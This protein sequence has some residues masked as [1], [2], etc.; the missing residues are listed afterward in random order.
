MAWQRNYVTL[1]SGNRVRYAL[2]QRDGSD[3]YFVRFKNAAG[4]RLER[5]TGESKK[6]R[7]ADEAHRFIREE[8]ESPAPTSE[9]VSW[10]SAKEQLAQAL[11]HGAFRLIEFPFHLVPVRSTHDR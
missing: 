3:V 10:E 1:S 8:Y 6:P 11:L 4:K 5:S 7:A 2:L 9:G